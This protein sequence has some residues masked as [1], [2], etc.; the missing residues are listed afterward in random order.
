MKHNA[1]LLVCYW[2]Q[3]S[4]SVC[5]LSQAHISHSSFSSRALDWS[6]GLSFSIGAPGE[7]TNQVT[8]PLK[9]ALCLSAS[10]ENTLRGPPCNS[11]LVFSHR[12]LVLGHVCIAVAGHANC[13]CWERTRLLHKPVLLCVRMLGCALPEHGEGSQKLI[14]RWKPLVFK[15]SF[16][17]EDGNTKSS[18]QR[19]SV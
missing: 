4:S 19:Q 14:P 10:E 15:T 5:H 3:V 17:E 2:S 11:G 1:A 9:N 8:R 12:V 16:L 13:Q 18:G 6:T 7:A